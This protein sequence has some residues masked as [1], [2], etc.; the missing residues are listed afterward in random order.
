MIEKNVPLN[1]KNWFR[2]GGPAKLFAEPKNA[3]EFADLLAYANEK[4]ENIFVLGCGANVLISDD[5]FD[6]LVIRPKLETISHE[7]LQDGTVLVYAGAGVQMPQLITYCLQNNIL[8]LEEFSGIPG[9]VGGAV[10]NNMHYF[11]FSLSDFFSGGTII[12]KQTGTVQ[13]KPKEWF[14]MGYDDSKL[15]DKNEYLID[16]TFTLKKATD[17]EAAFA[18][19]RNKEMVRHRCARYPTARTCGCF[20]RNFLPEEVT[21]TIADTAKKMI[22]VAYYLDKL[23]V[24]GA[25]SVGD[26]VVSHQHANMLVNKGSATSKDLVNLARAMQEKVYEAYGIIPQPECE[27]V[28]FAQ[29]PLL[30]P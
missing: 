11:Q 27:L 28:G 12:D 24:K 21:L 7:E 20:F 2:T 6:G 14:S 5:G 15:H 18:K 25:L 29:Y 26:A 8:G 30:T 19:G 9:S 23:G 4:N 13:E 3:Q 1:D 10:Y 22:Y 16:A 17:L